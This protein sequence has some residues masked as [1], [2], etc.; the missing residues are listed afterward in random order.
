MRF[1]FCFL[2]IFFTLLSLS[3]ISAGTVEN[4]DLR[5]QSVKPVCF[6]SDGD[7][8]LVSSSVH[9][10]LWLVDIKKND[11]LQITDSISAGYYPSL[12]PDENTVCYKSFRNIYGKIEQA[13]M[14]YFIDRG[15]EVNLS[16]WRQLVGTPCVSKDGCI[17]FT[18]E[19]ELILL[20]SGLNQIKKIN[21][22]CHVNIIS[23][24]PD[25]K[26]VAIN[27]DNEQIVLLNLEDGVR[28][29]ITDNA[30]SYWRPVFS[31]SGKHLLFSSFAGEIYSVLVDVKNQTPVML[32]I[33]ES[34]AWRDD[35]TVFFLKKTIEKFNVVKTELIASDVNGNIE[36]SLVFSERDADAIF[37]SDNILFVSGDK[38]QFSKNEKYAIK[39]SYS[40]DCKKIK[41]IDDSNKAK[42]YPS[43]P[44]NKDSVRG[45]VD[46]GDRIQ[47]TG[48]PY[49]HQVYDT[50]D[51]FC[52]SWACNATSAI[53]A[54]QYYNILSPKPY[55]V[56]TPYS[57][58]SQYG[59]YVSEIYT[60]NGNTYNIASDDSC[61]DAGYGGYGYIVR[62]DWADTKGY[63]RDYIIQ[64]GPSSAVDWSPTWAEVQTEINANHPFV[65]L[66]SLTTAGHYI[67]GIGYFKNQRSAIFNDP[68]GNK[69]TPGYP[70][71]D[72]AGA[73]Y[74]F[75]G[76]SN[77]YENLN[78]VH[79]YI[80]CRAT[81]NPTP[82]PSPTP[83]LPSGT[84]LILDNDDGYPTYSETGT[85]TTGGAA[86]YNGKT[87]RYVSATTS[88]SAVWSAN[89]TQSGNYNVS[90][91]H[92]AGT[93]R[94]AA[95]K[96]TITTPGGSFDATTDQ[97][98]NSLTWTLLGNY[99]L[100]KG[101][102]NVTLDAS[103]SSPSGK[104]VI[105]DAVWLK[106]ITPT[107]TPTPSSTPTPLPTPQSAQK[108][109]VFINY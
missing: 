16:G 20:D 83:P 55:T 14:I 50:L 71:Y 107:P 80:Y 102:N 35:N 56:S 68:Y 95:T 70:S 94:A 92:V 104:V 52:G 61:G 105:A 77:G 74:D 27:N 9:Q 7:K 72:G 90:V 6:S 75:P 53:M 73:I 89:L 45:V 64:H 62:N 96:F 28:Q 30:A 100:Q 11:T 10:G 37:N 42:F 22:G 12:S 66:N 48:V 13:A 65:L 99:Q 78:T 69:N 3:A 39:N 26:T 79:C 91:I 21:I 43:E 93:N 49:I 36:G 32:G 17:L 59:F 67:T 25:G 109:N 87:Y 85:W 57:H 86:G 58:I 101:I 108:A 19:N 40:F 98:A 84:D 97:S 18:I 60:I 2:I 106:L 54:I 4:A 51:T 41:F 5:A 88:N 46:L 81:V 31:P 82:T 34:P 47:I 15:E 33:G 103:G 23:I 1:R 29:V 76:Y 24:A 8:A 44:Y 38:L 63:M